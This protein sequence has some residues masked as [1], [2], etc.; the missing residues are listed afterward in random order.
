MADFSRTEEKKELILQII[1]EGRKQKKAAKD[2]KLMDALAPELAPVTFEFGKLTEAQ[3][4]FLA[5]KE[6]PEPHTM[7]GRRSPLRVTSFWGNNA[8]N[9][10]TE[11]CS[12][13]KAWA[14]LERDGKLKGSLCTRN[15]SITFGYKDKVYKLSPGALGMSDGRMEKYAP[16]ILQSLKQSGADYG[17]Y[18][19][20]LD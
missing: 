5:P 7:Q 18:L 16:Y 17:T 2:Q 8:M 12:L 15:A 20:F 3:K 9:M 13:F 10:G 19:G 14:D 1:K 11:M 4:A 6:N